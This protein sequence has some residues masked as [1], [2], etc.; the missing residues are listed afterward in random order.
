[1][2]TAVEV[3]ISTC[4]VMNAYCAIGCL[5]FRPMTSSRA[6]SHVQPRTLQLWSLASLFGA[7]FLGSTAAFPAEATETARPEPSVR[8]PAVAG[9]F[10]PKEAAA[11]T[12]A[13]DRY[14]EAADVPWIEDLKAVVSPHA[15]YPYSGPTAAY[16]YKAAA[17]RGFKTAILLAPSHYAAFRGACVCG[18][19]LYRTP[20]GDVP[21][22][23]LAR[24]LARTA[25]FVNEEPCAVRRPAWASQSPLPLPPSGQD[26]AHTWEH[27]TEVQVPF[28]QRAL[29][30]CQLIPVVLGDVDPAAVA[31]A[32][33]N[34]IDERTLLVA[35]SDLSHYHPYADAKARDTRT[36]QAICRLEPD[37]LDPD[38]A[39]G[40]GPVQVLIHLAKRKGWKA[41]MLDYRNSGDT[42]GDKSG[43]VGYTAVA[44]YAPRPPGYSEA[45]R[46]T[47]L[48][49]ARR[50]VREVVLER[51]TPE[52]DAASLPAHLAE[53]RGCFVTLTKQ[54]Q[55]R[56]CIGNILPAGPLYRAVITNAQGAAVR[57]GRFPPVQAEEL[58]Q[59]EVEVSVLTEPQPLAFTSPDDLL[60]RLRPHRDGVVLQ[61]GGLSATYLP[62]V[63][64]HFADKVKF[65]STLAR[66][67]GAGPDDWRKPGTRV[68]IYE[69]EAFHEGGREF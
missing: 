66:K 69:V 57:D 60:A 59:L 32:L 1:M 41:R 34:R 31:A 51:R 10:Y 53:P 4:L 33:A 42:A 26:T 18:K 7:V 16:A 3:A 36:I 24:E 43:V 65:L 21:V 68:L 62:Q 35:S 30:G 15:G 54:G 27:S 11:L 17:G 37:R 14:L 22:P 48:D 64:S 50:S 52:C 56:G 9:L 44:F 13:I 28:L 40:R 20:L 8:E 2:L 39:C 19:E 61:I 47:L 23:G 29:P 55:L 49:L 5:P 25:P 67:A 46:Q 12:R 58:D 6:R 45:E 38:D 63:W